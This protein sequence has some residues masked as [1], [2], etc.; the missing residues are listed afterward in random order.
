MATA[1]PR[2]SADCRDDLGSARGKLDRLGGSRAVRRILPVQ[3][4]AWS[5]APLQ[6]HEK[7]CEQ[8]T[9][10]HPH[11]DC[12][13]L[14]SMFTRRSKVTTLRVHWY[15]NHSTDRPDPCQS[16]G[17]KLCLRQRPIWFTLGPQFEIMRVCHSTSLLKLIEIWTQNWKA[18]WS[19]KPCGWPYPVPGN[20]PVLDLPWSSTRG[21]MRFFLKLWPPQNGW[22]Y[23][24]LSLYQWWIW[25]VPYFENCPY[26]E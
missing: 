26:S 25:G 16:V 15:W 1:V 21:Y 17:P 7:S 3:I 20:D 24:G 10:L 2:S 5:T 13:L 6:K 18:R 11:I 22:F 23:D 19:W 9:W 12:V 4:A 14:L 8:I